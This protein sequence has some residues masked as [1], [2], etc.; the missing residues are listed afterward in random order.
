MN[1]ISLLL[2]LVVIVGAFYFYTVLPDEIIT[3]WNFA[4]EADDWGSKTFHVIFIPL[5]MINLDAYRK[6]L[7]FT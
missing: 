5:L 4:G 1:L 6:I 2:I 7:V 3:H